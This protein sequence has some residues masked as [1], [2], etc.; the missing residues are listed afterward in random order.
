[1]AHSAKYKMLGAARKSNLYAGGGKA[2]SLEIRQ[3]QRK[4]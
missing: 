3:I 4:V 2:G 1:M